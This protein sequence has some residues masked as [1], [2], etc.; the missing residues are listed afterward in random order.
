MIQLFK[1]IFG[2]RNEKKQLLY[3][4]LF[5]FLVA[6]ISA[7]FYSLFIGG[8]IYVRG[9]QIHHFYFGMLVL[10]AGGVMG[11]LTN[12][13]RFRYLAS[14][15]IGVGIGLFADE[16]GLL[17]NCTTQAIGHECAYQFPDYFD[18]AGVIVTGI[19]VTVMLVG[20][21]ERHQRIKNGKTNHD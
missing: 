18:I 11:I 19:I 6:F 16:I 17:L 15:L 13:R 3:V 20:F 8:S 21:H 9:Y 10:S 5:F 12:Q 4:L 14:A 1:D 7:R 2:Y